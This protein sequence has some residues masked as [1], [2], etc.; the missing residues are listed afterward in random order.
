M[1]ASINVQKNTCPFN[2]NLHLPS[3]KSIANR[4]MILDALFG[5]LRNAS[6]YGHAEDVK[7]LREALVNCRNK[8]EVF[9]G[10]GGTTL[11]FALAYMALKARK[12]IN[13][14]PGNQMSK[15]PIKPLLRALQQL[16]VEISQKYNSGKQ[17]L[18]LHPTINKLYRESIAIDT[19]RS[20]QF[21]S[22][23]A[24]IAPALK[25][26]LT[27]QFEG[28]PVSSS[29]L[30]M[31]NKIL[32]DSGIHAVL[33]EREWR[34]SPLTDE[35]QP[36]P[37]IEK[38]WSAA[39]FFLCHMCLRPGSELKVEGLHPTGLQGDQAILELLYP[40][41]LECKAHK[42]G[43][44]FSSRERHERPDGF[45]EIDLGKTPDLAPA[46]IL[47]L[48][49]LHQKV[50]ISGLAH[51]KYKESERLAIISELLND[52]H[53]QHTCGDDCIALHK[54][55]EEWPDRLKVNPRDDHRLAM[56]GSL[57]SCQMD[58][59][60]RQPDCVKKSFPNY[61]KEF[62]KLRKLENS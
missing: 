37:V 42:T 12:P 28:D 10:N 53:V 1:S 6:F 5:T 39:V 18:I 16:G 35:Y 4:V 52:M 22:A 13:L 7:N 27:I 57:L 60:I 19:S 47:T 2:L 49:L 62:A 20:S 31:T 50:K 48:A 17:A 32:N 24:L 36:L 51:L 56:A 45:L 58:L 41:G 43:T 26:G 11:R 23:L 9:L 29:Y 25:N 21:A 54:F 40:F 38:D 34:I 55:P 33:E 46:L 61:W 14:I 44:H 30:D 8:D 3:S 59:E 15:R